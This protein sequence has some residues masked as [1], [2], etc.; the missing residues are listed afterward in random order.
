MGTI[1]NGIGQQFESLI[2]LAGANTEEGW[3][4]IDLE[5]PQVCNDPVVLTWAREN[6]SNPESGLRDLA[7][8]IFEASK[9]PLT[10]EDIEK[11]TRL[12]SDESY[13]GFRAACALAKRT[14]QP[15]ILAMRD[16]I[17]EK[18]RFF[19]DD[20][21]VSEVANKYFSRLGDE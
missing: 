4:K 17:R 18:I 11:L 19:I 20:A 2:A 5:L 14:N 12:M 8:T 1:E 21:S 16:S 10:S 13:P 15:E 6:T 3:A 9:V 7:A